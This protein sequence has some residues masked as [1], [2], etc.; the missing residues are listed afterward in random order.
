MWSVLASNCDLVSLQRCVEGVIGGEESGDI[1]FVEKW[2]SDMGPGT[3]DPDP[4]RHAFFCCVV[5]R[6]DRMVLTIA[7]GMYGKVVRSILLSNKL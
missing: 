7:K 4:E 6:S 3:W 2:T 1:R 5:S